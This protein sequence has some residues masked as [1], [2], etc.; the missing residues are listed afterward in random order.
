MFALR[1]DA[2]VC[3]CGLESGTRGTRYGP[4]RRQPTSLSLALTV[5]RIKFDHIKIKIITVTD[6][7]REFLRFEL[8]SN[9]NENY[10]NKHHHHENSSFV[11]RSF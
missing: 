6:H 3:G 1:V 11:S 8:I 7:P 9:F 5:V 2:A 10:S 4:P